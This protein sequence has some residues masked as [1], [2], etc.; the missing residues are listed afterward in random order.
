MSEAKDKQ[1]NIGRASTMISCLSFGLLGFK[2]SGKRRRLTAWRPKDMRRNASR[3][4]GLACPLPSHPQGGGRT[5]CA[6]Q[7]FLEEEGGQD[8][9]GKII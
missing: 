2:S 8:D 3:P 1:G 6:C 4:T 7:I 5:R 9:D